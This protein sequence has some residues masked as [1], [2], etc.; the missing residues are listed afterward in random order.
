MYCI[1]HDEEWG[2]PVHDD[3][4]L[5]EM[6][7]LEGAQ[8]GLA[9]ETVLKKRNNY[10]K[11]FDDFNPNKVA[12]YSE[13]KLSE[14]LQNKGI[15]RNRLKLAS[16]IKNAQIFLNIQA[17]FGSFDKYFWKYTNGVPIK[18]KFKRLSEIPTKTYLS[19]KISTDLKKRGMNFVG[20]TII[21]A[22][23]QAVGMVNDHE[24]C[25]FKYSKV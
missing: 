10:R 21:Y 14:L 18:N 19:D 24:V 17:E 13:K 16:A 7:I 22:F 5:F 1:Y 15:I 25:C 23:M 20:P 3:H 4:K 2:I 6:L 11:V 9:W 8:A 12:K